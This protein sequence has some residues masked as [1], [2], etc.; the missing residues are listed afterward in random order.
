[1]ALAGI[2]AAAFHFGSAF[3][4]LGKM[5]IALGVGAVD[6]FRRCITAITAGGDHHGVH[7]VYI[8]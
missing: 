2:A 7:A 1:M 3:I 6:H 4:A 8:D 5:L